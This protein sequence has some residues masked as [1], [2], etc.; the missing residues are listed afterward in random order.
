VRNDVLPCPLA[1]THEQFVER[2]AEASKI[3]LKLTCCKIYA[4]LPCQ[5]A[6]CN[7]KLLSSGI[8]REASGGTRPGAQALRAHQH[9]FCSYLK[10]RF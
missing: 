1:T 5:P 10:A 6:L 8:A 2:I 9:T 3:Y 4:W 7:N